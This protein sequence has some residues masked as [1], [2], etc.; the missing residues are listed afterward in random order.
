MESTTRKPGY[1]EL[2]EKID[3]LG[4]QIENSTITYWGAL[5]IRMIK[6]CRKVFKDE[7]ALRQFIDNCID[8]QLPKA[9]NRTRA[10]VKRTRK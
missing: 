5:L 1:T 3:E 9:K 8:E 10:K 2:A 6:C 7:K 4:N